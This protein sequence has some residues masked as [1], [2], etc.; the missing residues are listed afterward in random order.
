M[1]EREPFLRSCGGS[2]GKTT[3][4]QHQ[5]QHQQHRT[6]LQYFDPEEIFALP[7]VVV[8][9]FYVLLGGT[10]EADM[11]VAYHSI[12]DGNVLPSVFGQ[13]TLL[14]A[15]QTEAAG[16]T[17]LFLSGFMGQDAQERR[18]VFGYATLFRL[19]V[20]SDD[21]TS[22]R[23]SRFRRPFV[24]R[25]LSLYS[26]HPL[27]TSHT[28]T[29]IHINTHTYRLQDYHRDLREACWCFPPCGPCARACLRP[30]YQRSTLQAIHST[31]EQL[32][33]DLTPP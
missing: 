27:T 15:P 26:Y 9:G 22:H 1:A 12:V 7:P 5:Q 11:T 29:H 23:R 17:R 32:E 2:S 19:C 31:F 25:A 33:R 4:R 14:P 3:R 8:H 30:R 10:P 13:N 6:A 16:R 20:G 21:V 24:V 18:I 28:N